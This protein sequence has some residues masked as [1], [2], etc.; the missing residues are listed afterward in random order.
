MVQALL[1]WAIACILHMSGMRYSGM[2]LP[3]ELEMTIA[4]IDARSEFL[5]VRM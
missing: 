5:G 2:E 1:Q 3:S 4:G